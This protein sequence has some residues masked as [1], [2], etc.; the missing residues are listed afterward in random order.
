MSPANHPIPDEDERLS[1]ESWG[2]PSDLTLA[3]TTIKIVGEINVLSTLILIYTGASHNFIY[4]RLVLALGLAIRSI[5][6]VGI[7]LRDDK[8]V[9]ITKQ[10]QDVPI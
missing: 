1:L 2:F 7:K 4:R 6:K 10:C 3:L 9:W 8:R 5:P